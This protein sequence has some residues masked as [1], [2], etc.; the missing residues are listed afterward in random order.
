MQCSFSGPW[1]KDVVIFVTGAI[2]ELHAACRRGLSIVSRVHDR[3]FKEE[4]VMRSGRLLN[5]SIS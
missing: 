3:L 2:A 4:R 5:R 1:H